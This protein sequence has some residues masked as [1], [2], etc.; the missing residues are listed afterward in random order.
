M[1]DIS[2]LYEAHS[3]EEAVTL[4]TENPEARILAGGS[5]VL[6]QLRE[7]KGAGGEFVSIYMIDELRGITMEE[8]ETIRIGS[9]SSFSDVQFDP[10]IREHMLVLSEAV[11]QVGGPQ[12]R[13]IGT[14]GGNTCNGITSADSAATLMAYDAIVEILGPEGKRTLSLEDFYLGA[15]KVDL[16]PGEIQTAVL[17][18]KESY[19]GFKGSY[20]KYA[21][22]KALDIATT[23]C[24][25]NVK[26]S[27]DK[28]TIEDCRIAFGVAGPVPARART[29]E[30][31]IKGKELSKDLVKEFAEKAMKDV[32]PRDSWRAS[33][34]FRVHMMKEMAKRCLVQS[35]KD[36]GGEYDA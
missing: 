1:Y 18:P 11:R 25:V 32:N 2:K 4:L 7:G 26:L 8:D 9:L 23:T 19:E 10:I 27:D 28:K 15:K 20:Y 14:I 12:I 21:M 24:S 31:F 13:N 5:D 22:R 36:C 33:K 34:D 6:I 16:K 29:A 30:D 17:I 3:P 35:F